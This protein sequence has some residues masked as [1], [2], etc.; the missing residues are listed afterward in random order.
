MLTRDEKDLL[1]EIDMDAAWGHVETLS[2]IDKTSGTEG[3]RKAHEYV[4]EKLGQWGVS[5]KT[6]QFDSLISHPKEAFLKVVSPSPLD[7]E[8]ITHSFSASTPEDGIEAELV[9]VLSSPSDLHTQMGSL[10][11]QYR[12]A[13]IEG[14]VSMIRGVASPPVVWAAEQAGAL[15]QVHISGEEVLHEMIVTTVWGTPTPESA[16]R[17]PRITAVSVKKTDGEK[18]LDLLKKG[19]VKVHLR[20]KSETR[21]RSLPLTVAEIPGSEEPERFMLVHGHMDSW[22]VGTTDNCTGN[23]L[24]L[25]FAR[26]FHQHRSKLKRS[27]RIAWW[28]GHSTGRYSGSTWYA[29]NLFEDLDRN[30]FLSMNVD[31]PGVKGA[32]DVG[33]GGLMGTTEFIRRSLMDAVDSEEVKPNPYYM[34]AGDQSFYGIGIPSVAQRSYVPADSP[35]RG[36]WIGGSGSAWWWH[37]AH[38]TIDKAD[39]AILERDIKMEALAVFRCANSAVFPFNFSAVA[40]QYRD[41][42][43]GIQTRSTSGSFNL[44][45]VLERVG[46]LKA[47]SEALNAAI[48][49]F[50]GAPKEKLYDLNRTLMEVSRIL[51]STFYTGAGKYDQDPAHGIPFLPA[52]QE[53]CRLVELDPGTD[54]A[55][56]LRTRL[57]RNLNRVN[58]QLDTTLGKIDE[59]VAI[60]GG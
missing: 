56:F 57:I 3:E 27:V 20:A 10:P 51:T 14:K 17:I 24:L 1:S 59:A 18:L 41:A 44:A 26:L 58:H 28:S 21:W 29:D 42:A 12:K 23:S 30:C 34:R 25:E 16:A 33:G 40:D 13:G 9:Y 19:P 50:K 49:D 8:C 5:F 7:A 54:E 60:A 11:E 37:S 36:Q 6:Y 38:D 46:K 55:G 4:R 32:T 15:A 53:A 22:Y 45:P 2:T 48:A 52:L 43:I 35:L 39:K 31:S 47:R